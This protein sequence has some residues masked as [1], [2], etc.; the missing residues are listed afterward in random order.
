MFNALFGIGRR[1]KKLP[2]HTNFDQ[3]ADNFEKLA[4]EMMD[5]AVNGRGHNISRATDDWRWKFG[6]DLKMLFGYARDSVEEGSDYK[7][8]RHR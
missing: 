5:S 2:H 7:H 1:Y 8:L 3:L 6:Q 4:D